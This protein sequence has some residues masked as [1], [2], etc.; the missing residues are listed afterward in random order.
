M[1]DRFTLPM[2]LLLTSEICSST[3]LGLIMHDF[4]QRPMFN[5]SLTLFTIFFHA[6]LLLSIPTNQRETHQEHKF[7]INALEQPFSAWGIL[8]NLFWAVAFLS[9]AND[10]KVLWGQ[11]PHAQDYFFATFSGLECLINMFITWKCVRDPGINSG[12]I[13]ELSNRG[14]L[15]VLYF[16][17]QGR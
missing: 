15:I 11:R 10:L 16:P 3:Y 6:I 7:Y 1:A 14:L 13:F 4:R 12:E 17:A 5:I 9:D 8:A 2:S